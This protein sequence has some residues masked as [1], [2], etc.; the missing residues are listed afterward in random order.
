MRSPPDSP[1]F[2][3]RTQGSGRKENLG[4]EASKKPVRAPAI[5]AIASKLTQYREAPATALAGPGR[6][7]S[8]PGSNIVSIRISALLG[9]KGCTSTTSRVFSFT[10]LVDS[11][12]ARTGRELRVRERAKGQKGVS[13]EAKARDLDD[14]DR[15]WIQRCGV[16][17][18]DGE[19]MKV[20]W[21]ISDSCNAYDE[22]SETDAL[23]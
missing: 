23:Q 17:L 10:P 13:I 15:R 7:M 8:T 4:M 18:S 9:R 16:R 20:P 5:A 19:R 6:C 14:H 2:W 22:E 12:Q 21:Q 1:D 3:G 11:G